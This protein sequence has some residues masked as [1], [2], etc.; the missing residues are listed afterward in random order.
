MSCTVPC[1]HGQGLFQVSRLG[2]P[3]SKS[4]P[5]LGIVSVETAA[6]AYKAS[7]IAI[8]FVADLRSCTGDAMISWATA[9]VLAV[10]ERGH[11][12]M[13]TLSKWL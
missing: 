4:A 7:P 6:A 2:P 9:P 5:I 3:F 12:P 1:W 11:R 13:V 10:L 8:G